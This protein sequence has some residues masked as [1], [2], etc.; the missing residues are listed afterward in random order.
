MNATLPPSSTAA[1]NVEDYKGTS[2]NRVFRHLI[3]KATS[4]G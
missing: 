1:Q 4:S 2:N 3:E